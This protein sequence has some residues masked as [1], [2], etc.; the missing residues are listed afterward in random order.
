MSQGASVTLCKYWLPYINSRLQ[1]IIMG[2]YKCSPSSIFL[3]TYNMPPPPN[4]PNNTIR[5]RVN[6][7][8]DNGYPATVDDVCVGL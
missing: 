5:M 4:I 2:P 7:M 1:V 8:G 3:Q 6:G